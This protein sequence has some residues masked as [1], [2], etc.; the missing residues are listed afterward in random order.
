MP[1]HSFELATRSED[2]IDD[3]KHCI[4]DYVRLIPLLKD[5][6]PMLTLTRY[7]YPLISATYV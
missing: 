3:L 7:I 4:L 2:I 5:H 6:S 1:E